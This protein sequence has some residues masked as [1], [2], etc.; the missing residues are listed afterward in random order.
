MKHLNFKT[1]LGI[2][3]VNHLE[4][5]SAIKMGHRFEWLV[6]VALLAVV[7]QL[8]MFY[9]GQPIESIWFSRIVWGVFA[10]ELV[11]NLFNVRD[12]LRYLR[13]NWMSLLIVLVAFPWINWWGDWAL[14]IRSLRLILF[15]R[16]AAGFFQIALTILKRNRFGQ[17]LLAFAFIIVGAGGMFAYLEGRPFIDGVWYA[18]VTI[19]TVGYGD[20]VPTSDGGR[21][22]GVVLILF[23]VVFF[24]LVSANIA[25]FLI[26][27]DQRKSEA[28]I[29]AYLN[30]TEDHLAQLSIANEKHVNQLMDH[31]SRELANLKR[32]LE[33]ERRG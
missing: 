12:R 28:D 8:L 14:V 18:I 32:T 11:V 13:E 27:S 33:K 15:L 20:V 24:S 31:F 7:I 19:T 17:I 21:V 23:G 9:S 1:L 3:G 5:D 2:A 29:L 25:A 6:L 30:Q 22:F 26:G 16:F 4:S 10:L